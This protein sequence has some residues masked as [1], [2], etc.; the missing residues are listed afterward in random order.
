[1]FNKYGLLPQVLYSDSFNAQ[2]SG[3]INS[4]IT[5]KLREDAL[6]RRAMAKSGT[7]AGKEIAATKG[8]MMREV[9]LILTLTLGSPPAP[10][11]EFTW[12]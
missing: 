11:T 10:S 4:L 8:K 2:N 5:T 12:N 3:A 1:L 9:H 7:K 6:Q